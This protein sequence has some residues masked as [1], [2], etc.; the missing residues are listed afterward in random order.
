MLLVAPPD[1]GQLLAVLEGLIDGSYQRDEVVAWY[2]AVQGEVP[3]AVL[4]VDDGYWYFESLSALDVPIAIEPGEHWFIR[5]RDLREYVA[6]LKKVPGERSYNGITRVREHQTERD[7]LKWPLLMFEYPDF[8]YLEELGLQP[9]RGIFDVHRDLVEHSHLY[10]E[11]SL[12]LIVR[13]YDDRAHQLMV[14]GT[15]RDEARLK[16]F[17]ERLGLG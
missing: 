11:G 3:D 17:L 4:S 5:T 2:H 14:L 1:R 13:Q 16:R 8:R 7:A 15:D 10:F 6:D 9:V 12:Y